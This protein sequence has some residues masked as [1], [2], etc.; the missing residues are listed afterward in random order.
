MS[1]SRKLGLL[2]YPSTDDSF[3]DRFGSMQQQRLIP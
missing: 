1:K 3:F 2:D